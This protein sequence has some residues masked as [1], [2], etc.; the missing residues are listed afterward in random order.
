MSMPIFYSSWCRSQLISLISL[1]EAL[2][3]A[4]HMVKLVR[5]QQGQ[6]ELGKNVIEWEDIMG[7][8]GSVWEGRVEDILRAWAA[9]KPQ[10]KPHVD[11][12]VNDRSK[13]I[14]SPKRTA[15]P[16]KDAE[17]D[18]AAEKTTEGVKDINMPL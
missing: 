1:G 17:V 2:G 3:S 4:A 9:E 18:A 10:P 12:S 16:E 13:G 8:D 5:T 7:Q 11:K 15:S 6:F 14:P